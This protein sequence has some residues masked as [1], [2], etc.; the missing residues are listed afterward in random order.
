MVAC[1]C[2]QACACVSLC[3]PVCACVCA[4][5]CLRVCLCVCLCACLQGL[6]ARARS[7]SMPRCVFVCVCA[8]VRA[9]ACVRS[10]VR[11]FTRA[12]AC[13]AW[14]MV[15][16]FLSDLDILR[17]PM[18]RC[19]VCR[20]HPTHPA[21]PRYASACPRPRDERYGNR[22]FHGFYRTYRIH[23]EY[24]PPQVRLRLPSPPH[25]ITTT[26][27]DSFESKT[28]ARPPQVPLRLPSR[29]PALGNGA[30]SEGSARQTPPPPPPPPPLRPSRLRPR[31]RPA[32]RL[33]G[34]LP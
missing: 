29:A 9:R 2:V 15:R 10:C 25:R 4:C 12:R 31:C 5:V 22:I 18:P 3:A 34:R 26:R 17:A 14:R 19:P 13:R 7:G 32:G 1:G 28:S 21:R 23:R 33:S 24:L 6:H 30:P 20:K 16:K 27:A 8:R 11:A